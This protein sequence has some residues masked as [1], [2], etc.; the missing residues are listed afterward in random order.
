MTP[1]EKEHL[2]VATFKMMEYLAEKQAEERVR[3]G[4]KGS[5]RLE[6]E[7]I[8][9]KNSETVIVRTFNNGRIEEAM[10]RFEKVEN[11]KIIVR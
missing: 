8:Q 6:T 9:Y 1:S 5:I 3:N 2:T 11:G 7:H 4:S 10:Y